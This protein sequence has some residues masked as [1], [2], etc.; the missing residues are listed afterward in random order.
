MPVAISVSGVASVGPMEKRDV[1]FSS[2][3]PGVTRAYLGWVL[4]GAMEDSC[5]P[6]TLPCAL[7]LHTRGVHFRIDLGGGFSLRRVSSGF[8]DTG[9]V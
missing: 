3:H 4:S 8:P 1:A 9:P 6:V 7:M 2:K 5:I